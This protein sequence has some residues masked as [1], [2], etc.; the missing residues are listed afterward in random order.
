MTPIRELGPTG[1]PAPAWTLVWIDAREALV[2]IWNGKAPVTQRL[3]SEVPDHHASTGHMRH[4]PMIRHGGGHEQTAGDP[5]RN[6]HVRR[7]LDQVVEALPA[8]TDIKIMGHGDM[9]A[10]LAGA[11]REHDE[12]RP[13]PRKIVVE[14][15][16]LL[17]EPQLAA[18]LRELVGAPLRRRT[19]GSWR[20]SGEQ[21]HQV[22]GHVAPPR[23]TAAKR[24]AEPTEHIQGLPEA[25]PPKPRMGRAP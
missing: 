1:A 7:F 23:R 14:P 13:A 24:A 8:D 20:W 19:S 21:P 6:E 22:S 5:H 12:H 15:S 18:Q 17:T 4:D 3:V 9:L 10:H 25:K 2:M 11:I 16:Q